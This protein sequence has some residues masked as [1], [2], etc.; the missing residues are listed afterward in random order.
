M[1]VPA[2][3]PFL[4]GCW[5]LVCAVPAQATDPSPKESAAA[6]QAIRSWVADFEHGQLGPNGQLQKGSG[7]Q[8]D[9]SAELRRAGLLGPDDEGR[10]THL[11]VLQKLLY[12]AE[13]HPSTDLADAV[14]AVA[15]AG[16]ETAFLDHQALQIRELGHWSLMRMNHQGAWFLV[17]RAAAGERV[18]LFSQ[19]RP[20][21]EDKG[22]NGLA[23][24]PA[25]R[26][27][28]LRLLGMK[29]LPVFRSTLEAALHDSDPRVRLATAEAL[30]FQRRPESLKT[31]VDTIENERHPVVSQALARLLLVLLRSKGDQV[32]AGERDRAVQTALRQFGLCGW[33]TDMDLLALVE[34]FPHRSAVP[35]LI[36]ALERTNLRDDDLVRAVNKR[37]SPQLRE[38]SWSLLRAMTG[39]LLLPDE[40]KVWR[41][42]WAREQDNIVVPSKLATARPGN[43]KAQ[44]F[45]VPVT[46]GSIGFVID[47][48]GSMDEGVAGTMAS[49]R[50]G[51]HVLTRLRAAKEQ[52]LLAVQAMDPDS[53]YSL[54]T[55]AGKAHLW[56]SQ[57]IRPSPNSMR[58]LTEL[59]SR[60]HPHG[61]TNLFDGLSQA[62]ELGQLKFGG[63]HE[64]K[65]DE[66]FV[67]SDGEPTAG[68]IQN[69]DDMLRV[70][71]EANKYAKV[72]INC[73]FTGTGP[74]ADLL[75][76]LAAENDGVFVQR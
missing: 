46:G 70:V 5:L 61:G 52:M 66:L 4:V 38:K 68:E 32:E 74:G 40:A 11:D 63:Q 50:S 43:T 75:R 8:P 31:I 65:I 6:A 55:F 72:R 34:A 49:E 13:T 58:S 22:E 60:L 20:E 33:R 21:Q 71:R 7:L 69:T 44:F 19:L 16:L 67:L 23:V 14:L 64:T 27:A 53:Q 25:R 48:S 30:E 1:P 9:Y 41:E 59:L 45:G 73:V 15:S 76:R 54:W 12:F 36:G 17:L 56:T 2:S 62:L 29:G 51:N 47:T 28:A 39:A 18:P 37:A 24:G 42:F 57:P 26:V 3:T 35:V 10:L